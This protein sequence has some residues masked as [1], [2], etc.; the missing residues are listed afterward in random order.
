MAPT[1]RWRNDRTRKEQSDSETEL[2]TKD[3]PTLPCEAPK[4]ESGPSESFLYH[5]TMAEP[6]WSLGAR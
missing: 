5:Y 3:E 2:L 6:L 1:R 4:A